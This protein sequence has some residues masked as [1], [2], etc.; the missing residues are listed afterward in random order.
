[1]KKNQNTKNTIYTTIIL[2]ILLVLMSAV[3]S[4]EYTYISESDILT[5]S[6]VNQNPDPAIAG[7]VVELRIGVE[8]WGSS[9]SEGYDVEL[10]LKYPFQEIPG[11]DYI[12]NTGTLQGFQTNDDQKIIKFKVRTDREASIGSYDL[13][14]LLYKSGEKNIAGIKKT[15]QVDINNRENAEVIYID[16]VTIIPGQQTPIEFTINNVGAAP[17]KDLSF[18]WSN[19]DD[20]VLPVGASDTRYIKYLGIGEKTTISYDV[21]ADTNAD[22]GLYKIILTLTY[23]DSVTRDLTTIT[24]NAGIYVGGETDFD[25]AFSES[26]AGE[27]SFSIANIGSNPAASV[28][29]IIPKQQGWSVSG[30]NSMIIGNLN[31][32]DYTVASFQLQQSIT[33]GAMPDSE[34]MPSIEEMKKMNDEEKAALREKRNAKTS[35]NDN[36]KVQIAY[37]DTRGNREVLEKDVQMQSSTNTTTISGSRIKGAG[38]PG[39]TNGEL[40]TQLKKVGYYALGLLIVVLGIVGWRKYRNGGFRQLKR[41]VRKAI[42]N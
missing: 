35:L 32:G 14:V 29:V 1:M 8:N 24:N 13:D 21:I 15:L 12:K 3:V 33:G 18:S 17:L 9:S 16:Q 10:M 23:E 40:T 37:T 38:K 39:Q 34:D 5:A 22:P 7:N 4:A 20:V 36:L 6:L 30:S 31:K 26:S 41:K 2:S 42:T 25:V 19:E 11:E 27:T 28:S